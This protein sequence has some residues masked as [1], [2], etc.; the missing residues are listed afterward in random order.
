MQ[1]ARP[2]FKCK[3]RGAL[4]LSDPAWLEIATALNVTKREL[5]VI[6]A[7]FDN[8]HESAI[9]HRL[10]ISAHTTHTH[11]NRLFL[12]LNVTTRTELVLRIVEQMIFLTL[13]ETGVLPPICRLYHA[14]CC[15]F[16]NTRAK[17]AKE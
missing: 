1:Q 13:S 3:P 14:S 7:V 9:A 8:L 11:L 4:M 16:Q 17:A 6:Q 10:G 2:V 15:C 5:Q 12:K